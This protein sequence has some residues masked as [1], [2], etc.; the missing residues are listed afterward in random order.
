VPGQTPD[1]E[2]WVEFLQSGQVRGRELASVVAAADLSAVSNGDAPTAGQA[3]V[4][5]LNGGDYLRI[6][7]GRRDFHYLIHLPT[8]ASR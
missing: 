2:R 4:I 6:W 8:Q 5:R 7:V 3:S 1:A